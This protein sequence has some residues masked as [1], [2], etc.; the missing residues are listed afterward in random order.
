MM[1]DHAPCDHDEILVNAALRI[2]K[3]HHHRHFTA[4]PGGGSTAARS[5]L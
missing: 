2:G 3:P 1:K 4:L 5:C